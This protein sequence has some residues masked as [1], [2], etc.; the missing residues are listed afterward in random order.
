MEDCMNS[1]RE[2]YASETTNV[3]QNSSGNTMLAVLSPAQHLQSRKYGPKWW[4]PDLRVINWSC[5]PSNEIF[6]LLA[7]PQSETARR[8]FWKQRKLLD[9]RILMYSANFGACMLSETR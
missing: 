6:L 3:L 5:R 2:L 7:I 8:S 1:T 9:A 4:Q